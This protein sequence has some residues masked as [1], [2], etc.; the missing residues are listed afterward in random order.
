MMII[1]LLKNIRSTTFGDT[2]I[3]WHNWLR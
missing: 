1:V 2:F 3:L